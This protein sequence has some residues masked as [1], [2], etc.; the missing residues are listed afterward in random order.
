MYSKY[1]SMKVSNEKKNI[2]MQLN[3]IKYLKENTAFRIYPDFSHSNA[4]IFLVKVWA[5]E[6]IQNQVSCK[7]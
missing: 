3:N 6:P 7:Y 4:L 2:S 5:W 1:Y